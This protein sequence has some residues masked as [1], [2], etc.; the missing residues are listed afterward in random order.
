MGLLARHVVAD[1]LKADSHPSRVTLV[2]LEFLDIDAGGAFTSATQPEPSDDVVAIARRVDLDALLDDL[3]A[4][5]RETLLLLI[6]AHGDI[7]SAQRGSGRS[8]SAFYRTIDELRLWL[9][10]GGLGI[11]SHPRGKNRE[12]DR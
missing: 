5:P 10:A 3:P 9:R 7:A 1:R 11:A 2:P 6:A 8:C 12:V 4:Q